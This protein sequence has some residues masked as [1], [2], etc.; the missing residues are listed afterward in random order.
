MGPNDDIKKSIINKL[1]KTVIFF[2]ISRNVCKLMIS[3][4]NGIQN[5]FIPD[6]TRI[7]TNKMF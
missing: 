7:A 3:D 1:H 5:E 4:Q 2:T 6:F